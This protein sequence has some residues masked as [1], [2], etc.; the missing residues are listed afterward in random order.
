MFANASWSKSYL[1]M[2]TFA[3]VSMSVSPMNGDKPDN[4]E[5]EIKKKK[6]MIKYFQYV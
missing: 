5:T 4:L 3:I 6:E 1:A 2:V